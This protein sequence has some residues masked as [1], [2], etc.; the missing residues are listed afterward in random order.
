MKVGRAMRG[1]RSDPRHRRPD[2]GHLAPERLPARQGH[3]LFLII[4]QPQA[5]HDDRP[6]L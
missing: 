6:S 3:G 2:I 1:T 4:G 5:D